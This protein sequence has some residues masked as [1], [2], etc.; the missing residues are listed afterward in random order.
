MF[1]NSTCEIACL[2]GPVCAPSVP[3]DIP[4]LFASVA[5]LFPVHMGDVLLRDVPGLCKILFQGFNIKK[6]LHGKVSFSHVSSFRLASLCHR[7]KEFCGRKMR[8]SPSNFAEELRSK[9]K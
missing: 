5:T 2:E 8:E 4:R 3:S 7:W 9:C 1:V 6:S